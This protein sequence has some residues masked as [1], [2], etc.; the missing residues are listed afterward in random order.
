[1]TIDDFKNS[2]DMNMEIS[3][4]YDSEFFHIEPDDKTD[5]WMIF[6]SSNPDHPIYMAKEKVV[7]FDINGHKMGDI[8]TDITNATY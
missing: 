7:E 3:F 4:D 1:M 5:D 6:R 8:L 2:M